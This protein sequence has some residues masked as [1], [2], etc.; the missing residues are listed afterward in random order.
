MYVKTN[1]ITFFGFFSHSQGACVCPE[2]S[3]AMI[4]QQNQ[5]QTLQLTKNKQVIKDIKHVLVCF[6]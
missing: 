3:W 4:P 5:F 6:N 2:S 1:A